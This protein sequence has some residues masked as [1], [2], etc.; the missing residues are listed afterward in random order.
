MKQI[1]CLI[2]P[3]SYKGTIES[4]EAAEIIENALSLYLPN[5]WNI[6]K[7]IIA[8]GG[9][10]TLSAL[11]GILSLNIKSIPVINPINEIINTNYGISKEVALIES[12]KVIG[13]SLIPIHKRNPLETSSRGLGQLIKY[14][15]NL[16]CEK[17][18]IT[19]GDSGTMDMGIG[20]LH[21]LGAVFYSNSK[22][23]IPNTK[24]I[25]EI[26]DIDFNSIKKK[27]KNIKFHGL[28]DTWNFLCGP[29]GQVFQFGKQKGLSN[30]QT[31]EL[32]NGFK[33]FGKLLE[34]K[35][36][37]EIINFRGASASG[38]LCATLKCI[39]KAKIEHTID[40]IER[41]T[42]YRLSELLRKSDIT[43]TGEGRLDKQTKYGKVPFYV[44][45]KAQGK[46]IYLVGEITE[47]GLK[48][49][50]KINN[51]YLIFYLNS[52]KTQK[53]PKIIYENTSFLLAQSLFRLFHS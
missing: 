52:L 28:V 3:G 51:D 21:E 40:F 6:N 36:N 35:T 18:I 1:N 16:G 33:K 47:D 41:K 13:L 50:K 10:G 38:G 22:R 29:E 20:M 26:D 15:T 37:E 5:Y 23:I 9:E 2:V 8:D 12:S 49:I 43:I 17:I 11:K 7:F 45:S 4:F 25:K 14:V 19:M 31:V 53:K 30:D 44:A 42:N 39:F 34:N 48:D 32:D 46:C 27:Y 24:T